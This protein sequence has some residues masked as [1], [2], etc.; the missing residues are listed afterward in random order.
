MYVDAAAPAVG[1]TNGSLSGNGFGPHAE[2]G[3]SNCSTNCRIP[4]H[5]PGVDLYLK[6]EDVRAELGNDLP[7][8]VATRLWATQT[9][10]VRRVP[11]KS[12]RRIRPPGDDSPS[13]L[14]DGDQIIRATSEKAIAA[15]AHSRVTLFD[16]GSH[17]T[18]ISHP[19]AVTAVIDQADRLRALRG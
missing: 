1:G 18:L 8:D 6:K 5:P 7:A 4:G 12:R 15:R 9:D 11:W 13:Y 17:L 16:G 10:R 2:A 19:D 14:S 3:K